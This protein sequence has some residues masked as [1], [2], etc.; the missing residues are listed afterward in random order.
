MVE[1]CAFLNDITN[2]FSGGERII[3]SLKK[4]TILICDR[5]YIY[6]FLVK[7]L[8]LYV[9]LSTYTMS[10]CQILKMAIAN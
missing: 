6:N 9:Y 7:Y 5:T 3:C 4:D 1:Q 10:K 8:W 2:N